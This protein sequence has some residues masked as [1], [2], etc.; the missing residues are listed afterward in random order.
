MPKNDE[1]AWGFYAGAGLQIAVGVGLGFV[2]GWWLDKKFGTSPWFV[3]SGS[4]LGLASGMYL[5]IKDVMRMNK[6]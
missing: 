3:L 6:T 5:L 1:P 2:V 4:M